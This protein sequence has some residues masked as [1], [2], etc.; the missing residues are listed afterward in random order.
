[1]MLRAS[2]RLLATS[3]TWQCLED[4]GRHAP[5]TLRR[6]LHNPSDV[7]LP[8]AKDVDKRFAVQAERH[9][10]PKFR[11]LKRQRVPVDDQVAAD[12]VWRH[13]ADRSG[14]LVPNLL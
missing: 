12:V 10:P 14:R 7:A 1:M 13:L 6:R 8:F 9:G 4:L 3:G 2:A 11:V 5:Q